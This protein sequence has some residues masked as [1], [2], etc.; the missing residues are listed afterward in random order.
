MVLQVLKA[1]QVVLEVL[2]LQEDQVAQ[3]IQVDTAAQVMLVEQVI[4]VV[5]DLTEAQAAQEILV[6]WAMAAVQ[7]RSRMRRGG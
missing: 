5:L 3:D 4:K 6:E 1:D 2:E 7:A